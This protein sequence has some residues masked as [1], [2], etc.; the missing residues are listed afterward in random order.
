MHANNS[1]EQILRARTLR[2]AI[3]V[4]AALSALLVTAAAFLIEREV[5]D[6]HASRLEVFATEL[7]NN[8]DNLQQQVRGLARNDLIINSLIDYTNRESYLPVF[9]RSLELTVAQD[10]AIVFTDFQGQIITGKNPGT[11][12]EASQHFAWSHQV[13]AEAEPF[14]AYS[15]NGLLIAAPV[16]Y[17]N[18]AEGAIAV[19]IGSL[20]ELVASIGTQEDFAIINDQDTVIYSSNPA[21]LQPGTRYTSDHFTGWYTSQRSFGDNTLLKF[22]PYISAYSEMLWLLGAVLIALIAV[23][24]GTVFAIRTSARLASESLQALES[25]INR[26]IANNNETDELTQ[27][28]REPAEFKAIRQAFFVLMSNLAAT[29]ISRDKI[30]AVLNSLGEVLLVVDNDYQ[31]LLQNQSYTT[32]CR[33]LNV[34]TSEPKSHQRLLPKELLHHS[35]TFSF[36]VEKNYQITRR[37]NEQRELVLRWQRS[38]YRNA[39]GQQLGFIYVASNVTQEKELQAELLIKNQAVDSADTCIVLT[40]ARKED[41]PLTYVNAA[42]EKLTG[43]QSHEVLGLNCRF[44]QGKDTSPKSVERLR[45]AIEER[46]PITTSLL[47]YR[48]DG[49]SFFNEVT[50]TPIFNE[51]GEL[52]HYLGIQVDITEREQSERFLLEA[53][54]K[55]EE[56]AR[57]KS[58]FLA[59]M[60]H[61]IR[62]PINGVMGMLNILLGTELNKEQREHAQL[63]KSSADSLLHIINDILDFSKVEADKLEIEDIQFDLLQL[64]GTTAESFAQKSQDKGVALIID[65][66]GIDFPMIQSDPGRLRQVL[67]NLLSNAVKFTEHGSITLTAN[68]LRGKG[69]YSRL[70]CSV[71]DTGI[72]IPAKQLEHIFDAFSQ[73][74]SSTTRRFGGTGLGLSISRQLCE[75]MGGMVSASSVEGK[76]S[77]FSFE[78][79]CKALDTPSKLLHYT[80]LEH[81]P[82]LVVDSSV[83]SCESLRRQ[84]E[85]W[86]ATVHTA[87]NEAEAKALL[88][89]F[90]P[91]LVLVDHD[92]GEPDGLELARR[93]KADIAS[94]DVTFVLM[95]KLSE[96]A[97]SAY[98]RTMGM[99]FSFAKPA[100]V[101]D[102]QQAIHVSQ[103]KHDAQ[104]PSLP[105][106]ETSNVN[107]PRTDPHQ[108]EKPTVL[109]VE[110]NHTNQL[111]ASTLLKNYGVHVDVAKNGEEALNLLRKEVSQQVYSIV[112]MDCQMPI[113]D[114]FEATRKIRAG[115]AGKLYCD[116]PIIAMTANAMQGDRERCLKAG[117]SDYISK[118]VDPAE[119]E[120]KLHHWLGLIR[121]QNGAISKHPLPQQ[122]TAVWNKE[123]ALERMMH[124]EELLRAVVAS[125]VEDL[126]PMI[127][128]LSDSIARKDVEKVKYDAHTIKGAAAN[129]GGDELAQ[130]AMEMEL[131][132]KDKQFALITRYWTDLQAQSTT[133]RHALNA[134]LEEA[135]T[136]KD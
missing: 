69:R 80:Q 104:A 2:R 19:H 14:V 26:A 86:G 1:L 136:S 43:Y 57:L 82:V 128:A 105:S 108:G 83:P 39:Q 60:S 132:A 76:G 95:T 78:I 125:F 122:D 44:L 50:I 81:L 99:H 126:P 54:N 123:R 73:A 46:R 41:L 24:A 135:A 53:K 110:D 74:D 45:L 130:T 55:A 29:S 85:K 102:L 18:F 127:D 7:E 90:R 94:P 20:D 10:H 97:N 3:I 67:N 56:S 52:T 87:G 31:P 51:Q 111:V 28:K 65:T 113:M 103:H 68:L 109:L 11:F 62:T 131:A 134:F 98:F 117:M 32:L 13:L 25:S 21:R 118:P 4:L 91:A 15:E 5:A 101:T 75:L 33:H 100:T 79:E 106:D 88:A 115:N 66:S 72:G 116:I 42:F 93:L 64:L 71:K 59:T 8:L 89:Q 120:Q 63:A 12:T 34:D 70:I 129:V 58:D 27:L 77:T 114:G 16:I 107:T 40:D 17:A 61:E 37:T 47:N 121:E 23:L 38:E 22:E 96:R 30:E 133:L 48:K 35:E 9:F 84:F 124:R 36:S 92:C 112:F 119:V 6:R 49:S